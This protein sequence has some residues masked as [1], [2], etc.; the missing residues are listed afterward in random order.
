MDAMRKPLGY[1]LCVLALVVAVQFI[2]YPFYESGPDGLAWQIWGYINIGNAV[3]AVIALVVAFLRWRVYD[4]SDVR[5]SIAAGAMFMITGAYAIMFF[6]HWFS[7]RLIAEGSAV[8]ELVW[9]VVDVWF[10]VQ[11]AWVASYLLRSD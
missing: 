9:I 5:E 3:G 8:R 1:L 4:R 6:E 2:A 7:A 10:P 11:S